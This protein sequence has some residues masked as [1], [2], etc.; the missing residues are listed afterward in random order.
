MVLNR[1]SAN[2]LLPICAG[3][4]GFLRIALFVVVLFSEVAYGESPKTKKRA[5][6]RALDAFANPEKYL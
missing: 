1:C 5:I 6:A 2:V 3:I 4:Y